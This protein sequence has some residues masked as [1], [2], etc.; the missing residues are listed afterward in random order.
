MSHANISGLDISQ[1][2][3]SIM[4]SVEMAHYTYSSAESKY[5]LRSDK[6]TRWI[7]T[8]AYSYKFEQ[9]LFKR[10]KTR[11]TTLAYKVMR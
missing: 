5:K 1:F 6:V 7:L 9:Y 4:Q 11:F 8:K 3:S 2:L 10:Q